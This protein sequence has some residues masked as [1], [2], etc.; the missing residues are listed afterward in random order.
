MLGPK[1][2]K[3]KL[4]ASQPAPPG[5]RGTGGGPSASVLS[6][7]TVSHTGLHRWI[8]LSKQNQNRSTPSILLSSRLCRHTTDGYISTE[9]VCSE[10]C[11]FSTE[12]TIRDGFDHSSLL[13]PGSCRASLGL[14]ATTDTATL[15][16]NQILTNY[17]Y[18]HRLDS[19]A[20]DW[21][22]A[23]RA[24]L[25]LTTTARQFTSCLLTVYEGPFLDILTSTVRYN[26]E[27]PPLW[28]WQW[29][30][31]S[32]LHRL[33]YGPCFLCG[34]LLTL[35]SSRSLSLPCELLGAFSY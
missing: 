25:F 29:I 9:R 27:I 7:A 19:F 14:L 31:G 4:T 26:S 18:F 10:E 24:R 21:L 22:P 30:P 6:S 13:V 15:L 8:F 33:L 32:C 34:I 5:P 20:P 1:S 3:H 35:P 28:P 12:E 16:W 2:T 11:T 23:K 17:C